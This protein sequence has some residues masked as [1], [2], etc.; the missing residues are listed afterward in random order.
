MVMKWVKVYGLKCSM[1][2]TQG[3][4]TTTSSFS[5]RSVYICRVTFTQ[6]YKLLSSNWAHVVMYISLYYICPVWVLKKKKNRIQSF[7]NHQWKF[8]FTGSDILPHKCF[9]LLSVPHNFSTIFP[10]QRRDFPGRALRTW[11][12]VVRERLKLGRGKPCWGRQ[13]TI[14]CARTIA[15]SD[16]SKLEVTGLDFRKWSRV[17]MNGFGQTALQAL[18]Q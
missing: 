13:A 7:N 17:R 14:H 8:H 6:K 3:N 10:R 1:H 2:D 16:R 5:N 4:R 12:S 18:D 15:Q 11:W 9:C